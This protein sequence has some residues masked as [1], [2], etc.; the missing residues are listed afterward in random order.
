[1]THMFTS[2]SATSKMHSQCKKNLLN[3]TQKIL[4][5]RRVHYKIHVIQNLVSSLY[6]DY[7]CQTTTR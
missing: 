4:L 5:A 3:K 7:V 2:T 1:M 6:K